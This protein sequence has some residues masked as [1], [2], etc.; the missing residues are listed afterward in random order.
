M[1]DRRH[2]HLLAA[3]LVPALLSVAAPAARAQVPPVLTS[4]AFGFPFASEFPSPA[5]AASAGV[6]LA[7]RWLGVS[8]YENPAA[9]VPKGLEISPVFQR[10][11]RQ[12]IASQNRDYDQVIGYPEFAGGRLS[13]P[14]G[15]WGL[16]AYAWR[17]VLRLEEFSY[18]AGPLAQPAFV[19]ELT[20]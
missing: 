1:I 5:N 11:N 7:D 17:P 8:G 15:D 20:S 4:P 16:M 14:M 19:R 12:D 3:V 18:S 10:V 9:L 6:A 2:L 13:L